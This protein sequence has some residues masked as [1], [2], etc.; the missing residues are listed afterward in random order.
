M[1]LEKVPEKGWEAL[2]QSQ[3]TFNRVTEKVAEGSR[4]LW[5]KAK[6]G[7]TG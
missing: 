3:V 2:A 4:K 1:V 5:C 7:S 6:S